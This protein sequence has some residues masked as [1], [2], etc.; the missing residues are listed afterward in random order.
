VSE[1]LPFLDDASNWYVRRSR[2]RFW[3]SG[4]DSDKQMAYKT[5][6]YVLV[7]FAI[8][9][10]PFTPFLAEELFEKLTGGEIAESVH[11]LDWPDIGHINELA[12]ERMAFT[13]KAINEGLSQRAA[14]RLKIRQPLAEVTI[15]G[16][17]TSFRGAEV[18]YQSIIL[19]ELNVKVLTL[20]G[21][22]QADFA[23]ALDTDLTPELRQEG[24]MRE[25]VRHIQ[26]ARKQAGLQVDDRIALSLVTDDAELLSAVTNFKSKIA[27]E[28]LASGFTVDETSAEEG[29]FSISLAVE[30]KP[31]QITLAKA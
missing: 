7:Q 23:L 10:A 28:T 20:A 18:E 19:E 14:A 17:P 26:S 9:V 16:A 6:H 11:L 31:L 5:L 4:D 27:E 29:D 3:K 24:L 2:R 13:R 30:G 25:I 12:L 8:T 21:E 22:P 1:I 15:T